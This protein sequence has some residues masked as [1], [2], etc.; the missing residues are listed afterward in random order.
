MKDSSL[1]E[2]LSIVLIGHDAK[3]FEVT[4]LGRL[5]NETGYVQAIVQNALGILAEPTA[6]TEWPV[7]LF[8][9]VISARPL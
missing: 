6:A 8:S 7:G 9:I 5:E 1:N 3:K 2:Q 4:D